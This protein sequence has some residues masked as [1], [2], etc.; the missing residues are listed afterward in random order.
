MI[1]A[2]SNVLGIA[3]NDRSIAFAEL[4]GK[5]SD[6]MVR[7][8]ATFALPQELSFDDPKT[9]GQVMGRFLKEKGFSASR[10]IVGIPAKWL[11]AVEK[12]VP[13]AGREQV[14]AMLRMQAERLPLAES[15][16]VV[17]E[18]AGEHPSGKPGK[19]LLLA[20]LKKQLDKVTQACEEAGVSVSAVTA[21]GLALANAAAGA[22]KLDHTQPMVVL[23]RHGAEV[24]WQSQ[25]TPRMLKHFSV[26]STN[27]HGVPALGP[28]GMELRRAVSLGGTASGG[29]GGAASELVLWDGVGLENAQ[30]SE[31]SEKV[32]MKVRAGDGLAM[33]GVKSLVR[34]TPG[35]A[36]ESSPQRYA[37]AVALALVGGSPA[38]IPFDFTKSRLAPP[39]VRR[40]GRKS[41][42]AVA[43]AALLALGIGYLYADYRIEL[44]KLNDV[45][46]KRSQLGK[47]YSEVKKVIEQVEYTNK[48]IKERTPIMDCMRDLT[49]SFHDNDQ[50]WAASLT[51]KE[52]RDGR[53]LDRV[54]GTMEG[55][56]TDGGV[57]F[58]I[59]NRLRDNPK[60]NPVSIAG[61]INPIPPS[62]GQRETLYSYTI[63]FTYNPNPGATTQPTASAK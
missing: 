58:V 17:F 59:I 18:Y 6:R 36:D 42:W 41:V 32:G 4:S 55:K 16:D 37:A 13:P 30:V 57:P 1:F 21:T 53:D 28:L 46:A 15:G 62:R 31:L 27:G 38:L 54:E 56:T 7:R 29:S 60:F 19:V 2:S 20:M 26:P 35:P 25:G 9:L 47:E 33:L 8:A 23:G 3:V 51:F 44:S 43:I 63:K 49:L 5:G 39:P 11:I 12:E 10:A 14:R 40:F 24:V 45:Q 22:A 50:I 48:F 52:E 34:T 61:A